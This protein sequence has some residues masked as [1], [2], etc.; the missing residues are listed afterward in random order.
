[1]MAN[2]VAA[3]VCVCVYVGGRV[4]EHQC[5][6]VYRREQESMI[7]VECVCVFVCAY[8]CACVCVCVCMSG[9]EE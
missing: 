1:M 9:S 4:C 7:V 3:G 2:D 5:V 6:C 8:V